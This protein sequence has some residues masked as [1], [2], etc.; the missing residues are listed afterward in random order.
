MSGAVVFEKRDGSWWIRIGRFELDRDFLPLRFHARWWWPRWGWGEN[1]AAS[2]NFDWFGWVFRIYR[3]RKY[4]A[5]IHSA[6]ARGGEKNEEA[7][8]RRDA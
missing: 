6:M 5:L 2:R 1:S 4:W 8:L 3:K 7:D